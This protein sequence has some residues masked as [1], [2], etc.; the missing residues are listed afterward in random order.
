MN[1]GRRDD[2]PIAA[3]GA[4]L[5]GLAYPYIVVVVGTAV[6]SV[7]ASL[8]AFFQEKRHI[9]FIEILFQ[10]LFISPIWFALSP[11]GIG[12]IVFGT[13][14]GA[15][16]AQR[17]A[18]WTQLGLRRGA[19]R[20]RLFLCSTL[21][22]LLLVSVFGIYTISSW[23]SWS[24]HDRAV[25]LQVGLPLVL[26]TVPSGLICTLLLLRILREELSA[27]ARIEGNK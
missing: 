5:C 9:H 22:G 2:L 1:R 14:Y 17:A 10:A 6:G 15:I 13:L 4:L 21:S 27:I 11:F 23:A 25:T 8:G 12:A 24:S 20:N 26:S 19:I 18:K 7:V 16:A 3:K